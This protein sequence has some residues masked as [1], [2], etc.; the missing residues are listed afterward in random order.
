MMK[1]NYIKKALLLALVIT[2]C[3]NKQDNLQTQNNILESPPIEGRDTLDYINKA[4]ANFVDHGFFVSLD[5]QYL[6][7]QNHIVIRNKLLFDIIGKDSKQYYIGLVESLI[8][9]NKPYIINKMEDFNN[10]K[11]FAISSKSVNCFDSNDKEGEATFLEIYFNK[12]HLIKDDHHGRELLEIIDCL[13]KNGILSYT[14]DETGYLL[15]S[16][17]N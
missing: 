4:V 15:Y 6:G 3:N 1:L 17:G 10:L 16:N 2:S 13:F 12:N 5:V 11:K 8:R 14:D 9:N 7:T